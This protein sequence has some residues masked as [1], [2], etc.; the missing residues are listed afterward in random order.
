MAASDLLRLKAQAHF[1]RS[2]MLTKMVSLQSASATTINLFAPEA[3]KVKCA[4]GKLDLV[5]SFLIL[6]N[7]QAR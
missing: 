3:M 4:S 1:G 7:I 5:N 2:I 6:R